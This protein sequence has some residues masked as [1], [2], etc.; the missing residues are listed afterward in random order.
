MLCGFFSR[1]ISTRETPDVREDLDVNRIHSAGVWTW[2]D[3]GVCYYG[4]ND[5]SRCCV[6]GREANNPRSFHCA[7]GN[8]V[9]HY[10]HQ[11]AFVGKRVLDGYLLEVNL[12]N[13]K[14]IL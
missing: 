2:P 10:C 7:I 14:R 4:R 12:K 9:Y 13:R 5:M 3:V 8:D 11:H 1:I 6:C